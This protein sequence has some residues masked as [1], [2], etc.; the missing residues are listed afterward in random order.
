MEKA[1]L[2]PIDNTEPKRMQASH[3]QFSISA[4]PFSISAALAELENGS[5]GA[6]NATKS[7]SLQASHYQ[8]NFLQPWQILRKQSWCREIS[9]SQRSMQAS[10][11]KFSISESLADLQ[12]ISL[13]AYNAT[14]SKTMQASHYQFRIS[15]A[16]TDLEKGSLGATEPKSD[17]SKP[18]PI[19]H[20]N[21]A[22]LQPWLIF[23]KAALVYTM[24]QNQ[25]QMQ[26]SHY[27]FSI[28]IQ[29]LWSPGC[30]RR[31]P[32]CRCIPLNQSQS[33]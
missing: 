25:S 31:Q 18:L 32:W 15:A 30:W 4:S 6:Y 22:F 29:H 17:A 13:G 20:F 5:L 11:C 7:K 14:E 10:H 27:Q 2:M 16:L 24:P 28:S 33:K 12:K 21:S 1:A 23:R 9:Q 8:F 19:Q 3:Y 26:A